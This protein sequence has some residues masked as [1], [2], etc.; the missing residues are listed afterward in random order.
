[1]PDMRVCGGCGQPFTVPRR[2]RICRACEAKQHDIEFA[3]LGEGIGLPPGLE[4][5]MA[6]MRKREAPFMPGCVE[7]LLEKLAPLRRGLYLGEEREGDIFE[8][9]DVVRDF[10]ADDLL[11]RRIM[12]ISPELRALAKDAARWSQRGDPTEAEIVEWAERIAECEVGIEE[13]P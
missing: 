11:A 1:M 6:F 12:E 5:A 7:K 4:E 3:N 8:A 2:P 13:E 10:Y 9:M